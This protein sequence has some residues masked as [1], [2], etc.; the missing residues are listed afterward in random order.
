[1]SPLITEEFVGVVL[2]GGFGTRMLPATKTI[3]KALLPVYSSE[4]AVPMLCYPI[5]TLI[6][7]GV[8]KILVISSQEH[9]GRI[10]EFLG[11]GDRF[12]VDFTYKI[13][14]MNNPKKP[15]GIASALKL[16][17][18]FTK[19]NKFAVILGDNFFE[20]SIDG[21]VKFFLRSNCSFHAFLKE[22]SDPERFG[23]AFLNDDATIDRIVEKPTNPLSKLAV[24]GLYLYTEDVYN[25][26]ETLQISKR[27]ELEITDINQYYVERKNSEYTYLNGYWSDMGT[28][29]SI[30]R[31]QEF[32]E[33]S[34]FKIIKNI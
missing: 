33:K 27:G 13:Q 17:K 9:C 10:I 3:N 1:M 25:I 22:V 5:Y 2:A 14:D 30:M 28:P 23:C 26:A 21:A 8:K 20:S 18:S 6:T 24:T 11:D 19:D 4:G 15:P 31:T 16:A 7:G 12:N 34:K 32:I 29:N